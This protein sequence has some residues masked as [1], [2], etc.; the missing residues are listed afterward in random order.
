MPYHRCLVNTEELFD[1]AIV[2]VPFDS[3]VTYRPGKLHSLQILPSHANL[4]L[5][6]GAR[7]GPRAI[8]DASLRHIPSRGFH[9][10]VGLNP[11]RSWA[12]VLDCG[13]IPVTPVD[14]DVALRMMYEGLLEL[15][16]RPAAHST[17]SPAPKLVVLGGDHSIALPA[18]RALRKI[19][20]QPMALLHF[21]AHMD[22][23]HPSSYP[24]L[25]DEGASGVFNHG[26][27]F[28]MASQE[29]LLHNESNVHAGLRT[30]LTGADWSDFENDDQQGFL[31]ISTNDMDDLGAAKIV[32][33]IQ[34]RLKDALVYLSIDIDVLDP[35]FAPGTGAP[36]AGGWSSRELLRILGGLRN[37]NIVGADVVEVA[38]AYDSRGGDT[39]FTAAHL[40]YEIITS[41]VLKELDVKPTPPKAEM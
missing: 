18:L 26:S 24:N 14:N 40:V 22:T 10:T 13:D 21:D 27:M 35:A 3:A 33:L 20:G 41:M 37:L 5:S 29:G 38:P 25:W 23:L 32:E 28:W 9:P 15:G 16:E 34:S 2:G 4:S 17:Y 36:E 19:H 11:Y 8:R 1:I 12:R 7:L 39:A 31:R 6:T 30:R